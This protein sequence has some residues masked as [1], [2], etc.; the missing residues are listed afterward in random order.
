MTWLKPRSYYE[1]ELLRTKGQD[2]DLVNNEVRNVL[3]LIRWRRAIEPWMR[4]L[5]VPFNSLKVLHGQYRKPRP[6]VHSSPAPPAGGSA[7]PFSA[8]GPGFAFSP[9]FG[10]ATVTIQATGAGYSSFGTSVT[11]FEDA[12][13]I[14]GEVTA[15]RSWVLHR[16]GLLHSVIMSDF[17]WV[18]G[19]TAEGEPNA[20]GYGIYAFKEK[21]KANYLGTNTN[22]DGAPVVTGTVYLW[23]VVYEHEQGY[24]A[25][26][27]C[28]ASI[29]DSPHYDAVKLRKLYGLNRR[30]RKVKGKGE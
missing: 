12:G 29:D 16:D 4:L 28:I 20:T 2:D 13:I 17:A 15:H 11:E 19:G 8:S 25:S 22:D 27:A 1:R 30:K 26:K 5:K 7:G 23:G 9:S 21:E 14:A 10:S 18:P 24:R 3:L 6:Q